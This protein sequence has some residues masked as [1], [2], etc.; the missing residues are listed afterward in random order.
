MSCFSPLMQSL[1]SVPQ[2][3]AEECLVSIGKPR[4]E[5]TGD[6]HT[7]R[8]SKGGDPCSDAPRRAWSVSFRPITNGD[9]TEGLCGEDLTGV[10]KQDV[11]TVSC[12]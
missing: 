1:Q 10:A 9:A 11:K 3:R 5:Q 12:R 2:G 7:R 6:R 4:K 8:R